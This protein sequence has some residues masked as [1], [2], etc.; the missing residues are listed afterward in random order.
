[1]AEN[2]F[3][4]DVLRNLNISKASYQV[5]KRHIYSFAQRK[6]NSTS[7]HPLGGAGLMIQVDET[8]ICHGSLL[9]TPSNLDDDIPGVT[10]LVEFIEKG[11]RTIR[12][13]IQYVTKK[14]V[15]P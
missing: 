13:E 8:A 10:W 15:H 12:L 14:S 4:K 2:V 7:S 3:E 11:S 9:D 5:I 6:R 1:M